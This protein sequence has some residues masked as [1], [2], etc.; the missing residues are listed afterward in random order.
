MATTIQLYQFT[1]KTSP[2]PA[3]IVY[4]GDSANS[5]DEVQSTIAEVIGAYPGLLS[6]G[7]LTTAA[8]ELIYT[9][10]S[11]TYATSSLTAFGRSV[12]AL[13]AGVTT[14]TAGD[15]ATWDTNANL[16][17]NNS[18]LGFTAIVS[19]AGSTTLTVASA[20]TQQVTGSTTQTIVM[21]VASTLV[22]GTPFTIINSSTGNVTVNSSGGN[23]IQTMAANTQLNLML[24]VNSGTTAASWQSVYIVDSGGV[25]SITGTANQVIASASTGNITL[26]LPQSIATTSSP[27]FAALTLTNPLTAANG[28]TGITSLGTGVAT[29]L[30]QNVNGSG[31][32]ALTTSPTFV[33]PILGAATG[34]SLVTSGAITSTTGTLISGSSA[35]QSDSSVYLFSPTASKGTLIIRAAD[36]AGNRNKIVTTA[37]SFGQATTFTIPDPGAATAN[38]LLSGLAINSVPSITFSSTSGIIG[39]TTNNNAAA[40]SVGEFISSVIAQASSVSLS[41]NS[42]VSVANISLTAGDWDLYGNVNLNGNALTILQYYTCWVGVGSPS[43]PDPSLFVGESYGVAGLAVFAENQVGMAAP[44]ARVSVSGTTNAYIG[45]Q[46]GFT[47]STATACGGI[48]ARRVR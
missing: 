25:T 15:F 16:S 32:M 30:G 22:A 38:F 41:N 1:S 18:L 11:N 46:A 10:A 19:A 20:H 12:V 33:T 9:T 43:S 27:T 42:V 31:A 28:G 45:V 4:L 29:A 47:T 26:S 8:N 3:D 13:S 17:A 6:I 40:G 37:A 35:G 2:V 14:P 24:L 21:P 5:F 23:L 7:G 48:F 34:T 44:F 36:D 39:T